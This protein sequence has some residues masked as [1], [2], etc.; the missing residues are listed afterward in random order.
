MDARTSVARER[1]FIIGWNTVERRLTPPTHA[2]PSADT[3]RF[4]CAVQPSSD[5]SAHWATAAHGH[6]G[7]VHEILVGFVKSVGID[8]I[9]RV[10]TDRFDESK[11]RTISGRSSLVGCFG[12]E[13]P[14]SF[15]SSIKSC[16]SCAGRSGSLIAKSQYSSAS[17]SAPTQERAS[18]AVGSWIGSLAFRGGAVAVTIFGALAAVRPTDETGD[19]GAISSA[20]LEAMGEGVGATAGPLVAGSGAGSATGAELIL[21]RSGATMVAPRPPRAS[22]GRF[23]GSLASRFRWLWPPQGLPQSRRHSACS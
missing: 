23:G 2:P 11:R 19:G 12:S 18:R 7:E 13:R 14:S 21:R 1:N 22:V 10:I 17:R 20:D 16:R 6:V 15:K 4:L 9:H 5:D 3:A 8:R